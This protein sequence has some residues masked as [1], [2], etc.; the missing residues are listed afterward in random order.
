VQALVINTK[1]PKT[2]ARQWARALGF[3]FPVLLDSDGEVSTRYAPPGVLPDLPRDQI[4]IASN[5]IIDRE[6]RI[7]FYSLLD[8]A[9]FDARLRALTACLDELLTEETATPASPP[10]VVAVEEPALVSVAAGGATEARITVMVASGYHVQ[11]NPASDQFLVPLQLELKS[12]GGVRPEQPHYPPG[13]PYQLEGAA[14]DLLTYGGTVELVVPLR[15]SPSARPGHRV[16]QGTLRYQAC[17]TRACLFPAAVPVSV[18]VRV[19][20][21]VAAAARR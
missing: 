11:A 20:A 9:N 2:R 12:T 18:P 3:T 21:G 5:L 15:A 16:L 14:N 7:R 19:V 8:S 17:D 1:E 10:P 13:Q 6:G 4:P